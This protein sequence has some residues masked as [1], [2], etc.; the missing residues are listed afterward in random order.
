MNRVNRCQIF[1][2]LGKWIHFNTF[3]GNSSSTSPN[4]CGVNLIG[5]WSH[6]RTQKFACKADSNQFDLMGIWFNLLWWTVSS[7]RRLPLVT[8]STV[9]WCVRAENIQWVVVNKMYCH[10]IARSRDCQVFK[11]KAELIQHYFDWRMDCYCKMRSS[12]LF[13]VRFQTQNGAKTMLI[14]L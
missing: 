5:I 7:V 2:C 9:L 6:K 11:H 4:G 3:I 12:T 1:L 8:F 14:W 10:Q 13:W